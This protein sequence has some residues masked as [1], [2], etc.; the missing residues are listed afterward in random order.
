MVIFLH[1]VWLLF[2]RYMVKSLTSPIFMLVS[3]S[4]PVLYVLLFAPLL[5]SLAHM[6]GFPRGGAYNV[7][8]PGLLVQL[9]LFTTTSAGWSLIV[10]LKAGITERMRV[11]PVSRVALLLGRALSAVVT[12]VL[13]ALAIIVVSVPFGLAIDPIGVILVLLL[14]ALLGL[15][16]AS[17]SYTIALLIRNTDTFGGIAFSVTL[18]LLLLSGVLLPMSL[19][20]TWLQD[21]AALNPLRY[22]V[23]AA[24]AVFN[25]HAGDYIAI[26]G[27][28]VVGVLAVA[29]VAA[30]VRSF[31]RSL[32]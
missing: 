27:F 8:V 21:I 25:R 3:L 14:V 7:F 18:P 29:S 2:R 17:T 26:R 28:V 22:A 11:T 4:Q 12:L 30:A 19:A 5:T 23:D 20:P 10:E 1:D 31:S 16:M 13:Q 32:A 6:P 24:R 9:G 15:M